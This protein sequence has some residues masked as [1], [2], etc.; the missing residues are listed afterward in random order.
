M[1]IKC[2]ILFA[3]IFFLVDV[4]YDF[5]RT[6]GE[7]ESDLHVLTHVVFKLA[8]FVCGTILLIKGGF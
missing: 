6:M 8:G 7:S 3:T 4:I 2:F 1:F 5:S